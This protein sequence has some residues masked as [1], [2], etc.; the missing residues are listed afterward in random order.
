V[1]ES[2]PGA[3][4]RDQ[5]LERTAKL[6]QSACANALGN[7]AF[8]LASKSAYIACESATAGREANPRRLSPERLDNRGMRGNQSEQ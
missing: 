7:S 5:Q 2:L 1:V 6:F 3:S 4:G 8:D